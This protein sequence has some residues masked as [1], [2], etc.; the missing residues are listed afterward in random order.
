M[1]YEDKLDY[2][3]VAELEGMG[4]KSAANLKKSIENSKEAG[5]ARLVYALG[6]PNIGEKTAKTLVKKFND[7][8]LLFT[9]KIEEITE[10]DDFGQIMAESLVK[11]FA[12][13]TTRALIDELKKCGI[14]T[15]EEK[16]EN[17]SA[18]LEGMTFVI[19]GTLPTM[20]RNEAAELI[21]KNGGKVAGSVSSKTTYLLA[22]EDAGSKLTKAQSL[23]ITIITEEE[24]FKMLTI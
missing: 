13:K 3:K 8:E 7:I 17:S 4:K 14:R 22:G 16:S 6:I 5:L 23:G 24:L 20:K 21:E 10:I 1:N 11:F 18:R 2:D 15:S 12:K 9:A 19:T